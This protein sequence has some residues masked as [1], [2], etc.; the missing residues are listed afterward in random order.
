MNSDYAVED[1]R[2]GIC[3]TCDD[4]AVCRFPVDRDRPV[5]YCEEYRCE[6]RPPMGKVA[7]GHYPGPDRQ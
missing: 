1:T 5:F 6:P 3:S 2:D 4:S 7:G